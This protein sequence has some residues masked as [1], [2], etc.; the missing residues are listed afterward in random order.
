MLR[1]LPLLLLAAPLAAADP[2]PEP[3]RV[4]DTAAFPAGLTAALGEH[5]EYLG[6]E[7]GTTRGRV[8]T[9]A[10][11]RF[12]F[13]KV[14]AK[15]PGRYLFAYTVRFEYPV[16]VTANWRTQT[17]A[18]YAFRIAVGEAGAVRVFHPGG[19]GGAA[20][21]HLNTGDTLLIPVHADP[22]RVDHRFTPVRKVPDDDPAFRVIGERT[23]EHYR[24][25]AADPPVVRSAAGDRLA[26]IATWIGSAGNRPG[27]STYHALGAYLEFA[28]PGT[29][30]LAGRL[31]GA[32]RSGPG[33]PF[34]VLPKDRPVTVVM[35]SFG[36]TETVLKGRTAQTSTVPP[37][38]LDARVDDRVAVPCGGYATPGLTPPVPGRT[39]VVEALAFR[40]V[41]AYAP[42]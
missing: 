20:F 21:P 13:A 4:P 26:P 12:W 30:D 14:K 37:G 41:P 11:E 19:H 31:E 27:T 7:L 29:F 42:R 36:Y 24:K 3:K 16:R 34:R 33:V 32:D 1:L 6:G 18:E 9:T 40:D 8:G 10:G 5:F 22:Y 35:E 25:N 17:E 28:T 39:G 38:T 2:A 15:A 23:D